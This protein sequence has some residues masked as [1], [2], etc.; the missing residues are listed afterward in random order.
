MMRPGAAH[1]LA[2]KHKREIQ[3]GSSTD[4][5]LLGCLVWKQ[6]CKDQ[7]PKKGQAMLNALQGAAQNVRHTG[8]DA[9]VDDKNE[10]STPFTTHKSVVGTKR[11]ENSK[12][13]QVT[14][15]DLRKTQSN[16]QPWWI[17]ESIP[18]DKK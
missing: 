10:H 3:L 1:S 15:C 16:K 12:P 7:K 9:K 18:F 8:S 4:R 13:K 11:A 14:D 2:W 6:A 5:L 17:E